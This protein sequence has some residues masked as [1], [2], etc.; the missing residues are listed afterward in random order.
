MNCLCGCGQEVKGKFVQGHNS[1]VKDYSG[2]QFNNSHSPSKDTRDKMR[3]AKLGKKRSLES[4]EKGR[5]K[6]IGRNLSNE[7]KRKIGVAN[8]LP[9]EQINHMDTL[10]KRIWELFGKDDCEQCGISNI[11]HINKF[12]FRLDVH[13]KTKDYNLIE[14][15]NWTT[16]C[17]SCHITEEWDIKNETC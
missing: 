6:M 14:E 12:G 7:T 10:H 3:N 1:R 9:I 16:F 4:I 17:R 11:E 2:G 13:C 8:Q 5:Q 15:E